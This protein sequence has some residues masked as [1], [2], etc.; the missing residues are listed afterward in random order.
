MTKPRRSRRPLCIV[1][2]GPNGAGKTTFARQFLP[3]EA[4]VIWFVNA[5]LIASGLSPLRPELA[6][7]AAGKLLLREIDRLA[8]ARESFAFETTMSGVTYAPFL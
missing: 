5:G 6:A 4:G 3:K 7:V 1:I 2:A 8:A